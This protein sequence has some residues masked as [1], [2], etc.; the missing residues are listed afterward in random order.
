[1]SFLYPSGYP[2]PLEPTPAPCPLVWPETHFRRSRHIFPKR[3]LSNFQIRGRACNSAIRDP[4]GLLLSVSA[5]SGYSE[6]YAYD[7]FD[8]VSSLTQTIDGRSYTSSYQYNTANQSTQ[9]TYPSWRVINL[10]HD[11]KGRVTSVGSYLTGVTY[12][13]IGQLTGTT[14]GTE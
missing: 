12:N 6:N 10:G 8:R 1:M 7:G 5:G 11:S 2:Q 13:S 4:N 14:W 9:M 3:G